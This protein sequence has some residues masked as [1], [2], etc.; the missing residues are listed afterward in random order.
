MASC[1]QEIAP[2]DMEVSVKNF[3]LYDQYDD[4]HRLHYYD[5]A[6]AVVLY[7][8]GNSCPI[9]R[10]SVETFENIREEYAPK[11]VRFFMINSNLQDNRETIALEAENF[12]IETPILV[13]RDQIAADILDIQITAETFVLNPA[14]WSITYRGPIDDRLGYGSDKGK[15]SNAYL[16]DVLDQVLSGEDIAQQYIKTKGCAVARLSRNEDFENLTYV[17]DIAPLLEQ[18]CIKCHQDGGIA[19]WPMNGYPMV[20]GWSAMMR[21][22][23]N[24][25]IMPPWQADPHIGV[26]GNDISLER[27]DK[28]KILAWI[29]GGL[30][31]GEG[32]DPLADVELTAQNWT[33]GTP[34]YQI[35][36]DQEDIPANG[37]IDYRYQEKM[38]EIEED[39][40]LKAV[41]VKPGNPAVLHHV[42]ARVQYPDGQEHPVA[43]RGSEW[44]DGL[45]L[46]WAPGG[47]VEVFPEG[48]GRKIPA[49]SSILFQLHYTTSGK[50][51]S[52]QTKIGLYFHE[53]T[54]EKEY[55]IHGP[56]DFRLK[57]PPHAKN[58]PVVATEHFERPITLYAML[59]HMHYR[60]KSMNYVANY[61]DGTSEVVLNVADYNFN[62]QRFYYLKEPLDLPAG[63]SITV[64][65]VFDNSAQN[66]FNPDPEKTLYFGE[67]TFDEMMIGYMS[68]TY[69]DEQS[70]SSL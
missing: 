58:H 65:A 64:N 6:K 18:K 52:D 57:I 45:L 48:S 44:L 66:P 2:P 20:A 15:A 37:I 4:F 25:G 61:P 39:K 31:K 23:L 42:L 67:Q 30:K 24:T 34:A 43:I 28:R 9:V 7:V 68:F 19:P 21:E 13:D 10:K 47:E 5:D 60:G 56:A 54:P 70:L 51:E 3:G 17:N 12:N 26:Y 14:D 1:S 63:S 49:G 38:V 8:Q 22:V 59:P 69:Q 50:A 32:K 36:L 27:E 16:T 33:L 11:G 62:W 40:Y 41:E 53:G 46:G 55:V 29:D 35:L